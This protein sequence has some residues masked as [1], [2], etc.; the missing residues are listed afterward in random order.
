MIASHRTLVWTQTLRQL[1][2]RV[3]THVVPLTLSLVAR[4]AKVC[5][6]PAKPLCSRTAKL[7]LELNKVFPVFGA[8]FNGHLTAIG[9]D[10]LFGV[11]GSL[12]LSLIHGISTVFSASKVRLFA[13]EALEIGVDGHSILVRFSEIW[14]VFICQFFVLHALFEL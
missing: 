3:L 14:R 10:Q 4:L 5:V 1:V 2:F 7:T 13:F 11:V 6:T 8:I 9:A 12:I